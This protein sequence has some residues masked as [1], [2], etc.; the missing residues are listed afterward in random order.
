MIRPRIAI[1]LTS[2]AGLLALNVLLSTLVFWTP[3]AA[4]AGGK[5]R[6]VEGSVKP[7]K[8]RHQ[9]APV[10]PAQEKADKIEG[11][12]RLVA[13]IDK[14]GKVES[15]EVEE[16]SG[17]QNLDQAAI[18]AV[19]QWTFDPATRNRKPVAVSYSL[20]LRFVADWEEK[21]AGPP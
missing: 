19:Q 18:D 14:K 2:F 13:V 4:W 9:A 5:P 21:P 6:K 20:T 15:V 11:V 1:L 10:Y 7:P 12:V 8:A 16:S 3:G 17:N